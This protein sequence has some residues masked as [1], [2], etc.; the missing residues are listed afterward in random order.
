MAEATLGDMIGPATVLMGAAV[1]A[2]P[3][4]KRLGLGSVLGYFAAGVPPVPRSSA[5]SP[6]RRPSCIFRNWAWSC[7][8]S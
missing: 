3:L 4:F 7:S 6:M 2:V 1:V 8:C 5:L